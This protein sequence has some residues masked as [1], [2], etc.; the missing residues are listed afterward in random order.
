MPVNVIEYPDQNIAVI[1][2]PD[3]LDV[4]ISDEF[5]EVLSGLLDRNRNK[6]IIDFSGT[7]YMD[8]SGLGA[9]VSRIAVTRGKKGDIRLAAPTEFVKELIQIT[10]LNKI[11]KCYDD[12]AAAKHSYI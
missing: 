4:H 7:S 9:V 8:S 6:I 1:E 2:A 12:I 3:R 10:H 11:L 5:R